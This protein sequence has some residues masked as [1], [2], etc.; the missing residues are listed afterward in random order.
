MANAREMDRLSKAIN[1][2]DAQ[3]RAIRVVQGAI[4]DA[5]CTDDV[6][7]GTRPAAIEDAHA[8]ARSCI[9]DVWRLLSDIRA[10][11]QDQRL[12]GRDPLGELMGD[13]PKET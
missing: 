7:D 4:D 9:G 12:E 2:I 11:L 13:S 6:L 8:N 10:R 1:R 3:L 5:Y